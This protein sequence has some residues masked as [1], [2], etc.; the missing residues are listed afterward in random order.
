LTDAPAVDSLKDFHFSLILA[1]SP[2]PSPLHL[3]TLNRHWQKAEV[4]LQQIACRCYEWNPRGMSVY[5]AATPA[6]RYDFLSPAQLELVFGQNYTPSKL[7]LCVALEMVFQDYFFRRDHPKNTCAGEIAMVV[8]DQE[9]EERQKLVRLLVDT[10]RRLR[11][12]NELGVLF[13]QL[14]EDNITQGFLRALDDDLHRAGA[15]HDIVDA[16]HLLNLTP[17]GIDQFLLNAL[18]D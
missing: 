3:K 1:R 18:I 6:Y 15:C 12:E 5:V 7:N 13:A 4:I 11:Q 14:G 16:Q 10:T 9:P 8:L 2:N 17:A